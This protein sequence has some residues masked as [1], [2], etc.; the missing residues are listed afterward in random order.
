MKLGATLPPGVVNQ[1]DSGQPVVRCISLDCNLSVWDPMGK[2]WSCGESLFKCFKGGMT[3]IR[4]AAGNMCKQNCDFGISMNEVT[5]EIGKAKERLDI[6]D[7]SW[8][9][10]TLDD[11]DFVWGHCEAFM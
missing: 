8:Y 2:D 3:L 5:V 9:G 6:L 1:K 10:P 11:L 4:I 7:F